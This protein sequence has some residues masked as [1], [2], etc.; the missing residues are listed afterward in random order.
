M[1]CLPRSVIINQRFTIS[2]IYYNLDQN[3]VYTLVN[4]NVT[5][6]RWKVGDASHTPFVEDPL[7]NLPQLDQLNFSASQ[8][9]FWILYLFIHSCQAEYSNVTRDRWKVGDASHTP[10]VQDLLSNLPQ[11]DQL[12][13]SA[14]QPGF[15]ILCF[16]A[17]VYFL[18]VQTARRNI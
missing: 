13:F 4:S 9:G 14:S 2:T 15:W 10:S 11:L 12:N 3:K 17:S 1:L 6:D 5:R 7:L 8:P 16:D 18:L